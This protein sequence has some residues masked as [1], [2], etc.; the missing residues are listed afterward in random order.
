MLER[1]KYNITLD[2]AWS[3]HVAAMA[4]YLRGF[5]AKSADVRETSLSEKLDISSIYDIP[6]PEIGRN[7]KEVADEMVEKIFSHSMKIQH[8]RFFSFVTSSVSPFSLAGTILTDIYNPNAAGW[9]MAPGPNIIEEK[10]ISWMGSLAGFGKEC[11]GLFTSGG[12]LSNL[13]CMIAARENKLPGRHDLSRGVAFFSDQAHSSVVK[14]MRLMGLR[15]NQCVK[16]PTDEN[17]RMIPEK[18]EEAV[19]ASIVKGMKPFLVVATFG[20][21][22][23]GSIDPF[24][25]ISAIARKNDMWLHVDGAFGGSLLF[26]NTYR[27]LADGLSF[28]DSMSWDTHKWALQTYSCSCAIAKDKNTFL[29]T[30][31]E[32]PEYLADIIDADH[33]DGWDLGIEMSRPARCMKLWYTVQSVGTSLLSDIIEYTI[34]NS[35]KAAEAIEQMPSWRLLSEPMCGTVNFRYEP[36]DVSPLK[37]DELNKAISEKINDSGYAYVLTTVLKGKRAVRLCMI[38][39]RTET[40]D[41]LNTIEKLGSIAIELKSA[42]K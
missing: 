16:V 21:T 28:A 33:T 40:E 24:T 18:L 38:N 36:S 9:E 30:F 7:P 1:K 42:F 22:N 13:T 8:P 20:T 19:Q 10:L 39:G 2:E 5:I 17:F 4:D 32:H 41:V 23:T 34:Y 6:I 37:Y 27:H 12:S 11:G 29:R 26:S 31:N 35:K 14:G 25:A 15:D 3:R